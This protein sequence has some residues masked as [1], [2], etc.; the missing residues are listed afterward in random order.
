MNVTPDPDTTGEAGYHGP[1]TFR[2]LVVYLMIAPVVVALLVV[3][4]VVISMI[5]GALSGLFVAK[6]KDSSL[7][8]TRNRESSSA[9]S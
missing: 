1:R 3:P 7:L 4:V 8:A 9:S 6:V 2:G 5:L